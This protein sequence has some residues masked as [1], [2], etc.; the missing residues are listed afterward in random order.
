MAEVAIEVSGLTKEY[1]DFTALRGISFTV[2]R[3][4]VLGLLGPN[5]SGKTTTV[6]QL[7]TLQR[8]TSG[9]AKIC[10]HDVVAEAA[11]VR[12]LISLTGQYASLDESL[13]AA[14]NLAVFGRLTG[15]RGKAVAARI[16]E[17]AQQFDLG[18]FLTRRV[19]DLSGGMRRRVDVAAALITRP[20]VL[21][22]DE[23]TT[24]LD[25]RSRQSVWSLVSELKAM[26]ITVILT[27]Q[28]LEEADLL[29]DNIVVID[30]GTVIAQGTADELK[31]R[32][33]GSFCE[34]T[35]VR[36]AD[37]PAVRGVLSEVSGGPLDESE[38][39]RVAI[40]APGGPR[41]LTEVVRRLDEAD[42]QIADIALRRPSL[43]DVFLALT[44]RSD[45][46]PAGPAPTVGEET[47]TIVL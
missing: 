20:E 24:G 9:T 43:D 38:D 34:V 6:N 47:E 39:G 15:L 5:G 8:P 26:G 3:G 23:P 27:T 25:P 11:R 7:A 36:M 37:L 1:G 45:A 2:E 10:G 33:G 46:P 16:D 22:L 44:D 29:S 18:E 41:T 19:R 31:A 42:I 21:F 17:L 30:K 12:E 32:T 35:P 40:P 13:T 28:Y 14:E 4:E